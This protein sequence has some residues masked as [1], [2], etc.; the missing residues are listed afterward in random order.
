MSYFVYK[1]ANISCS[2]SSALH[3]VVPPWL[4]VDNFAHCN[5]IICYVLFANLHIFHVLQ[6]CVVMQCVFVDL[7]TRSEVYNFKFKFI[8]ISL[9]S[10][11]CAY[12]TIYISLNGIFHSASAWMSSRFTDSS[13]S[14]ISSFW[15]ILHMDNSL[16]L[17]CTVTSIIMLIHK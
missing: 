5:Y 17:Y 1:F 13:N 10:L 12:V 11:Q 6:H 3:F 4:F 15:N 16:A 7:F 9:N 14:A 8:A 2:R